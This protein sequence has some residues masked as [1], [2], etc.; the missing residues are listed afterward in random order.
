M[1]TQNLRTFL[2]L[3]Q[4]KNFTQTAEQ[5]FVAQ[6]TVT[7]RI[8]ELERELGKKLFARDN[9]KIELTN[10]GLV[11][12]SYAKRMLELEEA[13]HQKINVVSKYLNYYRIGT[14]ST[15]YESYLSDKILKFKEKNTDTAIKVTLG[16]STQLLQQLQDGILDLVYSYVPIQKSGYS[17]DIF[18]QEKLV[19]VTAYENKEYENGIKKDELI[20]ID[21]LMCNFMLQEV[22]EFIRGLF[23]RYY[24]FS[25]EIDNSTKLIPYLFCQKGYSFLPSNLV[26]SYVLEKKLREVPL[27]DFKTP[28]ISSY[29][30]K[31]RELK[32]ELTDL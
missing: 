10:E 15:I 19:L 7:N 1:D 32:S 11:F 3:S 20:K 2:L 8:A 16:H 26:E 12:Q 30:V 25:F 27:V 29:C 9:R 22:G 24:Q 18:K 14:T 5:L 31:N 4:V 21:Y 23:P 17:C 6:S 13:S 28:I